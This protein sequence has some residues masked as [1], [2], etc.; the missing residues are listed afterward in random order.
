MAS[1]LLDDFDAMERE[2][3]A[4]LRTEAGLTY[5]PLK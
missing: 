4:G 5:F 2:V 1:G 3:S